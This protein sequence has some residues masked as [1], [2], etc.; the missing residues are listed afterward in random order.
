VSW[1]GPIRETGGDHEG[2]AVGCVRVGATGGLCG[3]LFG[4]PGRA[5]LC[6]V[7]GGGSA[8]ADG[9]SEPLARRARGGRGRVDGLARRGVPGGPAR[10]PRAPGLAAG[11]GSGAGVL[12]W[13]GR[14]AAA[15]C[16]GDG[17][18]R[19]PAAGGLRVLPV[20]RA[21]AGG[22]HGA[23]AGAGR[24]AV[25]RGPVR[26]GRGAS[27]PPRRRGGDRLRAAGVPAAQ[28]LSGAH[29][30]E[31]DPVAAAVPLPGGSLA[32]A[33]GR[34]RARGGRLEHDGAAAGGPPAR[35]GPADRLLRSGHGCGPA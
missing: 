32:P 9:P 2:R 17:H 13:P 14:G 1:L 18:E 10:Q 27:F 28:R 16:A 34:G 21:G 30:G 11:A 35:G 3:R 24:P 31:R 4:V 7:V 19:G 23:V 12:A 25:P 20:R 5:G 26:A 22:R 8:A 15:G 6:P 33:P 29:G